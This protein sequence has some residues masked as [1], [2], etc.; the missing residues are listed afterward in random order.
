MKEINPGNKAIVLNIIPTAPYT[1]S[2]IGPAPLER[3]E[4]GWYLTVAVQGETKIYPELVTGGE[5]LPE[6]LVQ[7][8]LQDRAPE[9]IRKA[10]NGVKYISF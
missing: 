2:I 3:K 1:K 10:V 5:G 8:V 6:W 7:E 9:S 4:T